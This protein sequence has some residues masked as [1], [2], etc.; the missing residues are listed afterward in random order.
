MSHEL[1]IYTIRDPREIGSLMFT[2]TEN[3]GE[4]IVRP[5]DIDAM[6][7]HSDELH[8]LIAT[9]GNEVVGAAL[10]RFDKETKYAH[11]RGNIHVDY[12]VREQHYP[13]ALC[14]GKRYTGH[15]TIREYIQ[16]HLNSIGQEPAEGFAAWMTSL[17]YEGPIR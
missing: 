4:N 10:Y 8:A 1:K 13:S 14:N 9:S 12:N 15:K 7:R 5:S 6:F 11:V 17:P 2:L 16:T 3:N